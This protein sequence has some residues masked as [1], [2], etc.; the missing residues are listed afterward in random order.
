MTLKSASEV[1]ERETTFRLHFTGSRMDETTRRGSGAFCARARTSE[2]HRDCFLIRDE[3]N[4]WLKLGGQQRSR[5]QQKRHHHL[6]AGR[7]CHALP[8][9]RAW[10]ATA[11]VKHAIPTQTPQR[12]W[13]HLLH[14]AIQPQLLL[15]V[16]KALSQS[17]SPTSTESPAAK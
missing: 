1:T 17:A 3:T 12:P 4:F 13:A 10:Q 15:P 5:L 6:N 11:M 2:R 16:H 7:S 9:R 8:P 14:L